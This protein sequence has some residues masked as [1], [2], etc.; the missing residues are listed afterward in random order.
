[1]TLVPS[2]V[3]LATLFPRTSALFFLRFISSCPGKLLP[4]KTEI[5]NLVSLAYRFWLRFVFSGHVHRAAALDTPKDSNVSRSWKRGLRM[6]STMDQV[7]HPESTDSYAPMS[8]KGSFSSGRFTPR[9]S[10]Y[11]PDRLFT[12][13]LTWQ[14]GSGIWSRAGLSGPSA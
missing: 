8:Q 4:R 7:D 3:T 6:E 1:M 10:V 9:W 2:L 5:P 12:M 11:I 14:Y 13:S